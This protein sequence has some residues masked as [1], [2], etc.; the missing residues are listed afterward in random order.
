[1][2]ATVDQWLRRR[3]WWRLS[4]RMLQRGGGAAFND[5]YGR[6]TRY[7]AS[8]GWTNLKLTR[9]TWRLLEGSVR[10]RGSDISPS[11]Q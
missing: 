3:R 7:Y 9:G 11:W 10:G 4:N 6:C 2:L 8:G 5:Y 1:M